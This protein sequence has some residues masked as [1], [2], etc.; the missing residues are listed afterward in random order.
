[1]EVFLSPEA[2]LSALLILGLRI[3]NQALDTMRIAMMLR[4]RK[5][6]T[7][8]IGFSESV[9]FVIT[10]TSVLQD[11]TNVLNIIAY[12]GGFA[13][14]NI[15]GMFIEERLAIGFI[16]M[17]VIS[18][19]RGKAI[20]EQLRDEGF[21]VTEIPALGKDGA[22]SLLNASVQRRRVSELAK[23][24]EQI[25]ERS[26]GHCRRYA[27]DTAADFGVEEGN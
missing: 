3:A 10:L 19:R 12:A 25:D 15:V 5:A 27:P 13:T 6:L 11:L 2:W 24:V 18:S 22:V 1:M 14:G 26:H 17:R 8:V 16:N 23:L 4:G 20:V 7:W 9:I 21:A